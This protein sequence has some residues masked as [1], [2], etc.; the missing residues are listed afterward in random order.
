MTRK[1]FTRAAANLFFFNRFSGDILLSSLEYLL[2]SCSFLHL[3][4]L[5]SCV[6]LLVRLLFEIK[7]IYSDTHW[8]MRAGWLIKN[9]H[10]ADFRKQEYIFLTL[11]PKYFF[12][13]GAYKFKDVS[14]NREYYWYQILIILFESLLQTVLCCSFVVSVCNNLW[15]L[16]LKLKRCSSNN[17][18][19]EIRKTSF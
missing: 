10:P 9:F 13:N 18:F 5:Y 19:V 8:T 4:F 7:V 6:S 15:R 16:L 14:K 3:L 2:L 1:I 12:S 17:K 11:A